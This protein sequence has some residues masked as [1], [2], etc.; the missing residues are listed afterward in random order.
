MRPGANVDAQGFH[1]PTVYVRADAGG[2]EQVAA[3][4]GIG[5][6][7]AAG[8]A[9]II[10]PAHGETEAQVIADLEDMIAD[11]MSDR[12]VPDGSWKVHTAVASSAPVPGQPGLKRCAVAA[13]CFVDPHLWTLFGPL[14]ETIG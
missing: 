11:G 1:M 13:L 6:P 10:F 5:V 9:G 7:T 14:V 12:G 4:V 2:D 8:T 3:G